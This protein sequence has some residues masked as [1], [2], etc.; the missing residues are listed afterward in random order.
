MSKFFKGIIAGNHF[1]TEMLLTGLMRNE[2]E[3]PQDYCVAD[4]NEETC[5]EW[6][7][8]FHVRT[9]MN[10]IDFV[11]S[12]AFVIFAFHHADLDRIMRKIS[13]KIKPETLVISA[14]HRTKIADL[15]RYI[16]TR[17]IIR[18]VLNP[19]VISGAGVGA[20]VANE[21]A[22]VD[23]KS[24]AQII[25][26]NL[27]EMIE[28]ESEEELDLMREF[29][30][31]NTFLSYFTVKAMVDAGRKLGLSMKDS[32]Y[33]AEQVL[34][35]AAKTLIDDRQHGIAMLQDAFRKDI[36]TEA[37]D[38]I[39]NYGVYDSVRKMISKDEPVVP[40]PKK[41]AVRYKWLNQ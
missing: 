8:K 39:K 38:L 1:I 31:A 26:K 17:Q 4:T 30:L 2:D 12:A 6:E 14:M 9:T 15:E 16:P 18:L 21:Y 32:G 5:K 41:P 24:A 25:I 28:V 23:A 13:P 3:D 22:T 33:I 37:V 34:K 10:P 40:E 36:F 35:G 20:Y 7:R 11:G 19:S 29:I 27:G